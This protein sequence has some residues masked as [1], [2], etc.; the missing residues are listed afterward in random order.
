MVKELKEQ[1]WARFK[2]ESHWVC[3]FTHVLNLI[4]QGILR[5]FGTVKQTT[6]ANNQDKL[7]TTG[8]DSDDSNSGNEENSRSERN[9]NL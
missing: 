5:P 8:D 6:T 1:K 7:A 3:C 9:I 2:G 4:V